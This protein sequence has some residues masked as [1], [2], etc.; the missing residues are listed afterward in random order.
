[1][2]DGFFWGEGGGGIEIFDF[3]IFWVGKSGKYLL[4]I[5]NSLRIRG[6]APSRSRSFAN[7]KQ[8]NLFCGCFN[9]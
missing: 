4:G 3:G 9:I 6:S 5:Q 2:I 1:M 8:P 7:K